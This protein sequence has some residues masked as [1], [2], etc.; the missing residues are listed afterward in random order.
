MG[1]RAHIHRWSLGDCTNHGISAAVDQLTI[2]NA[3]GPFEPSDDAPA[4]LIHKHTPF[5][6]HRP[7][8]TIVPAELVDGQWCKDRRWGMFGGNFAYTS[9]S[10]FHDAIARVTGL[11]DFNG[12]VKIHDRF[13]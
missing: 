4:A 1:I 5:G 8:V 6:D 7:M 2:V 3:D 12:A 11:V 13:E 10:R 9:D